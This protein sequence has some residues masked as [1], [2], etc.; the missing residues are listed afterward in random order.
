MPSIPQER[1]KAVKADPK[2]MS[3]TSVKAAISSPAEMLKK[4]NEILK[5]QDLLKSL[6][7]L[8]S[9]KV[10]LT[11]VSPRSPNKKCYLALESTAE[12]SWCAWGGVTY[13]LGWGAEGTIIL[14]SSTDS[15]T[16]GRLTMMFETIP[17]KMYALE[18]QVMGHGTWVLMECI[19]DL[20]GVVSITTSGQETI[21][22]GFKADHSSRNWYL[23]FIPFLEDGRGKFFS[24][25]LTLLE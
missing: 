15:K 1:M 16:N 19:A 23:K 18:I 20:I 2:K 7:V 13:D 10:I 17:D 11:P 21:V 12:C 25:K 8:P 9:P 6:T 4:Y 5:S 3:L 14:P 24:C 22:T